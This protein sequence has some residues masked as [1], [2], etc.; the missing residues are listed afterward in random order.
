MEKGWKHSSL[1]K[2]G[3]K[4]EGAVYFSECLFSIPGWPAAIQIRA[5]KGG[6]GEG[7]IARRGGGKRSQRERRRKG[8]GPGTED[9]AQGSEMYRNQAI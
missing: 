1:E 3:N 2:L 5:E 6:G 9:R 7:V 4:R 8:Q